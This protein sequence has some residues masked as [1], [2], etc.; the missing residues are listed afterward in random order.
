IGKALMETRRYEALAARAEIARGRVREI[1]HE[2]YRRRFVLLGFAAFLT[3]VF[4]AP[5]SSLMN[6]YLTDVHGFSNS[7]IAVFRTIT[8]GIPGLVGLIL[9]GRLAEARGRRP[10]AAI[11]LAVATATQM[12]FFLTA[13]PVLWVMAAASILAAGASGIA[14]GSL[15]VELFPTE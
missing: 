9:G 6:K 7:S 5:S 10:I 15:E 2:A 11:G 12:V 14:V 3:S 1:A 8:T 13:G 4:S